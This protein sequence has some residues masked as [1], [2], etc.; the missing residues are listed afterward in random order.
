MVACTLAFDLDR[1]N[2]QD[3]VPRL[4]MY[5][6]KPDRNPTSL[7]LEPNQI[8]LWPKLNPTSLWPKLNPTSLWPRSPSRMEDPIQDSVAFVTAE[9]HGLL[10]F[11]SAYLRYVW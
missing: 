3:Y 7:K 6:L 11:S 5:R 8:S 9:T 4:P 10:T 2:A 1:E